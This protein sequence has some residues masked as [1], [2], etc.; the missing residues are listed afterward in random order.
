MAA[1]SK[2]KKNHKRGSLISQVSGLYW[3]VLILIFGIN[4]LML[5]RFSIRQEIHYY[6][7][8]AEYDLKDFVRIMEEGIMPFDWLLDYWYKHPEAPALAE[9]SDLEAYDDVY[10]DLD[11]KYGYGWD[12]S[13][14]SSEIR[15]M[16][17]REQE[18]LSRFYYEELREYGRLVRDDSRDVLEGPIIC[19]GMKGEAPRVYFC[20]SKDYFF[21][22]GVTLTIREDH[23][24]KIDSAFPKDKSSP[25]QDLP[26]IQISADMDGRSETLNGVVHRIATGDDSVV[27]F[28]M[29]GVDEIHLKNKIT[30]TILR[31]IAI[32]V[33]ISVLLGFVLMLILHR[34]ILRPVTRI[35]KGLHVYVK[36]GDTDE[37]VKT[38]DSIRVRNEIGGLAEDIGN[39]VQEMEAQVR[40]RQQLEDRQ[41]Q[42]SAE[43]E[44]AARIQMAMLPRSFP[45]RSKDPRLELYALMAPAREVGG[46]L[47]DFFM[48]DQDRLVLVI[49]DVSGKGIP[50]ALFMMQAKTLVREI[51]PQDIP[52]DV[53]MERVNNGL[54]AFNEEQQFITTWMMIVN[55]ATGKALEVNAGHTMPAL[56]RFH[57]Q[58]ELV[59]NEHDLPLGFM[60][61]LSFTVNE[62]QLEPG[63]RI[64]VYTDGVNEAENI[65]EEQLGTNRLLAALNE[66]RQASQKEIL[67]LVSERV[68]AFTGEAPQT[69]DITM[70]GMT[71]FG[72]DFE[73]MEQIQAALRPGRE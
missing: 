16:S 34:R 4:G 33:L 12:F 13:L 55:L 44:N 54:Y 25:D 42:L 29:V 51:A 9:K 36:N 5:F 59:R 69:D 45:D 38:M 32:N 30:G 71:F 28:A 1:T 41:E 64:F 62:W 6:T 57:G 37:V 68:R 46:D 61:N 49:A 22:P 56:C 63:D 66:E 19:G 20:G 53:I 35:Q 23:Q 40:A 3:C 27:S 73:C 58:Y 24:K 15:A 67:T 8:T 47:Y 11:A 17:E 21:E 43:L 7:Q 60:E 70:L 65:S 18:A 26:V 48:L 52:I 10:D 50:A 31:M 14:T 39:M 72:E 2:N